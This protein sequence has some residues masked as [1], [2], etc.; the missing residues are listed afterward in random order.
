[1]TITINDGIGSTA[2]SIVIITTSSMRSRG[3][4]GKGVVIVVVIFTMG[5]ITN[6]TR[7]RRGRVITR[8]KIGKGIVGIISI[9][10]IVFIVVVAAATTAVTNSTVIRRG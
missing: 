9:I 10:I 1:V 8:C 3:G 6:G 4:I 2:N 5:T 7:I